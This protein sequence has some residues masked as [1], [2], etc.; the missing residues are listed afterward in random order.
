MN[1]LLLLTATLAMAATAHAAE[2]TYTTATASSMFGNNKAERYDVAVLIKGDDFAGKQI[3][4]A[5]FPVPQNAN[6]TDYSIWMSTELKVS[7][8][9]NQPNVETKEV[10]AANG[11]ITVTFDQPY[12]VT[13]DGVY[14]GYTVTVASLDGTSAT[15]SP[16]YYE[17]KLSDAGFYIHTQKTTLSWRNKGESDPMTLAGTITFSGGFEENAVQITSLGD[18]II[19]SGTE[20]TV[21]F[22]VTNRGTNA[23]KSLGVTYTF[24]THQGSKTMVLAT[25]VEA[26]IGATATLSLPLP[27]I[28][29]NGEYP[30]TL[31]IDKVNG[32]DNTAAVTSAQS[33]IVYQAFLPT[34]RA[35]IEEY[36]GTW[37]G[38]CPIGFAAMEYMS[39]NYPDFIGLAYHNND[40]MMTITPLP[41]GTNAFP[42]A[43]MDRISGGIG[44]YYGTSTTSFHIDQDWLQRCQVPAPADIDVEA[45]FN[46]SDPT[47]I[48]VH[49][50]LRFPIDRSNLNLQMAYALLADDLGP[51]DGNYASDGGGWY[52]HNYYASRT[53]QYDVASEIE[54]FQYF[55]TGSAMEK[56]RYNDVVILDH[57]IMGI[58]GS[59]PSTAKAGEEMQLAEYSFDTDKAYSGWATT[60]YQP[61][62]QDYS[63]LRVVALLLDGDSGEILNANKANVTGSPASPTQINATD[64]GNVE[65]FDLQGRR[66]ASPARGIFLRRTTTP[67]GVTTTKLR[68]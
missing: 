48:D 58:E 5:T 34:H 12:T 50:T 68:L 56:L 3:T 22:G 25:P 64:R 60:A 19:A 8:K 17:K 16:V 33:T 54:E 52:Q 46:E 23:V 29:E 18:A 59:V 37:C 14:V 65:Y 2:Q 45:S 20:G 15:S 21:S 47:R 1:K 4:A 61:L 53:S 36:T 51:A 10:T 31:T 6:L 57:D 43:W 67:S 7:N 41:S 26:K 24:G 28:D 40:P 62:V 11:N 42:T 44:I 38:N 39:K 55:L 35:V 30:F 13:E 49:T 32:K 9:Y 63:K 66:I 27:A